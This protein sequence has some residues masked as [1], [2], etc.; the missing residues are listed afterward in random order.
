MGSLDQP[1]PNS[2]MGNG[3]HD[4][5]TWTDGRG[6]R[7]CSAKSTRASNPCHGGHDMTYKG[8]GDPVCRRCNYSPPRNAAA[9]W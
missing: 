1:C 8:N 9:G 3:T 6:C 4:I 2:R 5:V 7:T